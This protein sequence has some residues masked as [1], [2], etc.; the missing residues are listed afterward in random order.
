M[1]PS[2][3]PPIAQSPHA[4][5][6]RPPSASTSNTKLPPMAQQPLPP[7]WATSDGRFYSGLLPGQP[8][9]ASNTAPDPYM[10]NM[11]AV[12]KEKERLYREEQERRLAEQQALFQ[13]QQRQY[14]EMLRQQQ[15]QLEEAKNRQRGFFIV[16]LSLSRMIYLYL[17]VICH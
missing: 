9:D 7:V 4:K 6:R 11:E 17:I 15:L 14:H 12:I 2:D 16:A 8:A 3:G 1:P 10:L 5:L 13:E